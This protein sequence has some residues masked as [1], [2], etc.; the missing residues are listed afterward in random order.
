[1]GVVASPPVFAR[2]ASR[3]NDFA[4]RSNGAFTAFG[5]FAVPQSEIGALP[6]SP[7]YVSSSGSTVKSGFLAS[8]TTMRERSCVARKASNSSSVATPGLRAARVT[9]VDIL[10]SRVSLRATRVT[11]LPGARASIEVRAHT[12]SSSS[13]AGIFYTALRM[14]RRRRLPDETRR[15][16]TPYTCSR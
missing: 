6:A 13:I 11:A 14:P 1:M 7:P 10:A 5:R 8:T 12:S 15:G 2:T 9:T 4:A 3:G 16:L